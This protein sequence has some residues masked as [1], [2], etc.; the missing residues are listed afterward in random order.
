MRSQSSTAPA[1][2]GIDWGSSSIR[3]FLI[4]TSGAVL[5]TRS[6]HQGISTLVRSESVFQ[7]VLNQIAGDWLTSWPQLP[8]VAC[9]MVGSQHGW[10]EAPY[11]TCV[12]SAQDVAGA[13]VE[14]ALD[15]QRSVSILPGLS[16]VAPA[17]AHRLPTALLPALL[18]DVMRG[19]ETQIFG[20]L[21]ESPDLAARSC[22]ILPGTHSKWAHIEGGSVHAFATHMTGELFALLSA[23]SVLGR[24]F[25]DSTPAFSPE[26]FRCGINS[27]RD[28]VHLG[29]THQL[30]SVRTL[31]LM[32]DIPSA[33]LPDYLSGLLIGYEIVAGMAWRA[34]HHLDTAPIAVIG[35][36]ALCARYL[37]ALQLLGATGVRQ[38]SNTA[39]RGLWKLHS[40]AS[41]KE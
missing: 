12:A 2:I 6:G 21:D 32:G 24:L 27:A 16:V 37:T 18:P 17:S 5:E 3:V 25:P 7:A 19:E 13:M 28:H 33:G 20:V 14:V 41:G 39:P 1:L 11:V 34:A 40:C 35:D 38:F 22:I 29:L 36:D 10:K 9:G 8:V 4:D 26:A 15:D 31:G 23:H 30:F